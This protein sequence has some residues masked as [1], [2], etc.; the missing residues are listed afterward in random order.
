MGL[1]HLGNRLA[2]AATLLGSLGPATGCRRAPYIDP[3]KE[4]PPATLT[5]AAERDD[6]VQAAQF[7]DRQMPLQ[8]PRVADPRTTSDPESQEVWRMTLEEAIRIGLEN[9]EV[10]R[11]I[12]LG[13]QG[14]P[15]GGF[16]PAPLASGAGQALGAANLATVYDPAVAETAIPQALSAFDTNFITQMTW[17]K[18][19]QPFNNA[20]QAGTFVGGARFPV[21]FDQDTAQ[22]ATSLQ[23]RLATGGQVGITQ[24]INYLYS[25]APTNVTP[26]A[27]TT[28]LQML[29]SQPLLGSAPLAGQGIPADPLLNQNL[30]GLEANR[31]GIVVARLDADV[32]VWSFKLEVMQMIRSIE[33]QY[34]TLAQQQ[35]RL[36]AAETAFELSEKLL[37][38][39]LANQEVGSRRGSRRDLADAQVQVENSRL[40]LVTAT[41]DVIT[42]ERQL[43]NILGLPPADNRRIVPV[44]EPTDAR[45]QPD[46]ESSMAQMVAYHPDIVIRQL[47]VRISELRLLAARNQLLPQL[48]FDVLYQFNGL[49]RHLD[50]SLKVMTG[51]GL[52]GIEPLTQV[53][54]RAAGVNPVPGFYDNFQT[55]QVGFTF[56]MPLGFRGPL[57]NVRQWQY[58]LLRSRAYLQQTVHDR[59]HALARFFLEVDANYKQYR[60]ASRLKEAAFARLDYNKAR[61]DA[62]D[63]DPARSE[64]AVTIQQLINSINQWTDAIAQEALLKSTYNT[65]IAVFEEAKGTLLAYNNIALAEGPW[66]RQAYVQAKDQQAGHRQHPVGGTG[67]YA[68]QPVNGPATNDPVTPMPPPDLEPAGP[69]PALPA[70]PGPLSP[71][72]RSIAPQIPAGLPTILGDRGSADPSVNA[73]SVLSTGRD[74]I[75][76][77]VLPTLPP[78][79]RSAD[80]PA[81]DAGLV[82]PM[83]PALPGGGTT[84]EADG[85]LSM[86]AIEL[87]ALP[88]T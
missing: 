23:K 15:V 2:L 72:P 48:S 29:F 7:L 31:A 65:S 26:S 62:G 81:V 21:I 36:W 70:P 83:L 11:V 6:Q 5:M 24:N 68:P 78:T 55:W 56:Q 85:T 57:S 14:I 16:E 19:V 60:A 84:G 8:M 49:G 69:R 73:A 35:V 3:R 59:M 1:T 79:G 13:A 32:S 58:S 76:V 18:S 4:V 9:S 46:W 43:R 41:S 10:I 52:E 39:V 64:E 77:E 67:P 51:A 38:D 75:P 44:T 87:P 80:A 66:P 42:T 63:R 37:E 12:A 40:Q 74:R 34:W 17:G 53:Q 50:E 82:L 30:S 71:P 47:F 33:Q 61:Y 20:I 86:P 54:Q 45:L 22:F 25:N 28:N 27:Y 88:G